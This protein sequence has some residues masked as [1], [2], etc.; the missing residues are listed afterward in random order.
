MGRRVSAGPAAKVPPLPLTIS[1][2]GFVNNIIDMAQWYQCLVTHFRPA[3][4]RKDEK[5]VWRTPLQ[6]NPGFPDLAIARDGWVILAECKRRGGLPTPGQRDWLRALGVH[7][8]L[9]Y[10][11]D[12]PTI[13]AELRDGPTR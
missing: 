5:D 11:G 3:R 12:W 1:E 7:G 10:P 9:W 8:R 4:I 6:G 13:V 2:Q